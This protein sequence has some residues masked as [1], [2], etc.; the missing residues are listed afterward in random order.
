MPGHHYRAFLF[1][2]IVKL[3]YLTQFVGKSH[4]VIIADN[5]GIQV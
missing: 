1:L 5:T 3:E 2:I 4:A